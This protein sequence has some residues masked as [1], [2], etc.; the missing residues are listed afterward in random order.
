MAS[1]RTSI[2]KKDSPASYDTLKNFNTK[3]ILDKYFALV[4]NFQKQISAEEECSLYIPRP[5]AQE[6]SIR[7]ASK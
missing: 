7:E 3:Q 4:T 5:Y 1:W 6:T 2:L